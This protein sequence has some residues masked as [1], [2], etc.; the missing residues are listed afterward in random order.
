M[1]FKETHKQSTPSNKTEALAES[2]NMYI[3]TTGSIN[4]YIWATSILC[5]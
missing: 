3:W 5:L 4:M 1:Q 2:I